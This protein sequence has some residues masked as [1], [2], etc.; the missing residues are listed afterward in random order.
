LKKIVLIALF[1]LVAAGT[2]FA[3]S[4]RESTKLVC[5]VTDYEPMN[6]RDSRGNWTGFDTEFAQLVGQKLNMQV[7]FQEIEWANKYQELNAGTITCIWN[8]FTANSSDD[9]VA[10]GSLVDF[11]Y[12]YMINH[13]CIVIRSARAGEFRTYG[14]LAGKT[15]A[16]E[17]GSAGEEAAREAVGDRG[18]I[19][20][21]VA[22]INTFIEVKSGAVDC[23]VIDILLA[24]RL[25]GSGDYADLRIA[26][27]TLDH[28][29]YAVGFK[30]GSPLRDQVNRAIKELYDEGKMLELARK[31][32][33]ENSL[34]LDT[35]FRG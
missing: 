15:A 3:A 18:R 17:S 30:K 20:G 21:T 28:E 26:D 19:V 34:V 12:S 13:Q 25:A 5:G 14:D 24:Q 11:T 23:A 7:E 16:A 1:V 27:I 2:V 9:G 32:K 35:N 6:F 33:L 22:Q 10:R 8:G 4:S 31:Y 29:V